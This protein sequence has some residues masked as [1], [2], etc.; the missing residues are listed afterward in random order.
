MEIKVR[1]KIYSINVVCPDPFLIHNGT[2]FGVMP[3]MDIKHLETARK[4]YAKVYKAFKK[5]VREAGVSSD[6]V[7]KLSDHK[8]WK[9]KS[10]KGD[11]TYNVILNDGDWTCSCKG[12]TF[13]KTCKHISECKENL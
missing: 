5:E 7:D 3:P 2:V 4:K 8:M 12:F 1:G 9:I 10:S 11:K 6:S 13:R